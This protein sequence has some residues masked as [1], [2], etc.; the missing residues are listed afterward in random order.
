MK[1]LSRLG[2]ACTYSNAG[3]TPD[4][5][6]HSQAMS[7]LQV[8]CF[9]ARHQRLRLQHKDHRWVCHPLKATRVRIN[10]KTAHTIVNHRSD[11]R[12][13]EWLG[14]HSRSWDNVM[15]KLLAR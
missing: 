3:Q 5:T 7:Y 12:H 6:P 11:D 14:F 15:E 9:H 1:S 10:F 13:V 2:R 8:G 4:R